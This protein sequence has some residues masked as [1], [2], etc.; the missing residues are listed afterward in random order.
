VSEEKVGRELGYP[1]LPGAVVSGDIFQQG[2]ERS[3]FRD[4]YPEVRFGNVI[5]GFGR[6]LRIA[7]RHDYGCPRMVPSRATRQRPAVPFRPVGYSAT[8]DDYDIGGFRGTHYFKPG[9]DRLVGNGCRIG[10]I[11]LAT[12]GQ[13]R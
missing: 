6:S 2:P 10:E 8:V 7:S 4:S 1:R 9:G 13:D 12:Y 5:F 11:R 3:R